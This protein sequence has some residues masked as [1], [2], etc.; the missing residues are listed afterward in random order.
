MYFLFSIRLIA[1]GLFGNCQKLA[2]PVPDF[3]QHR[4]TS[5]QRHQLE[6]ILSRLIESG[7]GWSDPYTQC[8]IATVLAAYRTGVNGD[9]QRYFDLES[10]R[11]M[12]LTF[13]G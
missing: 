10:T 8:V 11:L 6:A 5:G 12:S 13:F 2:E 7:Y 3:Y 9:L 4:L 1:D